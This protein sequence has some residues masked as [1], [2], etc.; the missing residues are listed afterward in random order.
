[1]LRQLSLINCN[2]HLPC[3][4]WKLNSIPKQKEKFFKN[5]VQPFQCLDVYS[6]PEAQKFVNNPQQRAGSIGYEEQTK[7]QSCLH[8]IVVDGVY[9]DK[10]SQ[11]VKTED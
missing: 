6:K 4:V 3:K 2:Q 1:M 9:G 8:S 10:E 7:N 11:K 5:A